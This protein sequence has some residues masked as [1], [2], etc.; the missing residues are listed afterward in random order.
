MVFGW[1]VEI[2]GCKGTV[3]L[4]KSSLNQEVS[5]FA[6]HKM[7]LIVDKGRNQIKEV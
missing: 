1:G 5:Q 4:A 3:V 2:A 7:P 6:K